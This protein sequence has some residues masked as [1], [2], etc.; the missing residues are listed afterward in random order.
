MITGNVCDICGSDRLGYVCRCGD[1]RCSCEREPC[2]NC[3]QQ[4]EYEEQQ[5]MR[6]AEQQ[7]REDFERRM[8]EK[9]H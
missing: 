9:Y 8:D 5:Q 1:M 4:H 7:E 2:Q 6:E 3:E